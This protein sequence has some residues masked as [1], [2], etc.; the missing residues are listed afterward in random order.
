M[1]TLSIENLQIKYDKQ[2]GH[3]I[4]CDQLSLQFTQGEIIGVFGPNGSGKTSFL[5]TLIKLKS[6]SHGSITFSKNSAEEIETT[7]IAYI[8]QNIQN[9]FFQWLSL[10]NNIHLVA[11]QKKVNARINALWKSFGI[12]FKPSLRPLDCSGGMLQQ[13]AVIRAFIN[14][15]KVIIGDEPFSAMDVSTAGR[16]RSVFREKV[17]NNG[18]IAL[19]ALHNLDDLLAV[20]DKILFIPNKPFSSIKQSS[21]HQIKVYE[22]PHLDNEDSNNKEKSLEHTLERLF[23]L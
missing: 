12:D 7:S 8:P 6:P 22:N 1:N 18:T 14:N 17:K 3:L 13:V 5:R 19:L 15:P 16:I 23:K 20:C 4:I 21:L 11:K 2:D 9:S 10:K